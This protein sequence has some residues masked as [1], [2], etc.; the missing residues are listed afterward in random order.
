M[1]ALLSRRKKKMSESEYSNWH[2]Y[3]SYVK[4]GIRIIACLAGMVLGSVALLAIGLLI[5]ECVGIVEE[6]G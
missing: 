2:T 6:F 5:A 4:S 1:I 3:C